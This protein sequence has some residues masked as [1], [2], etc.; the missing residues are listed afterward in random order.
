MDKKNRKYSHEFKME[1]IRLSEEEA[2]SIAEVASLLGIKP[3]KLTRWHARFGHQWEEGFSGN[4][5]F[6]LE[7]D[8]RRLR[9]ENSHL[10]VECAHMKKVL[11]FTTAV[12]KSEH[13]EA[14]V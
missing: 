4:V 13:G 12:L 1:A 8:L 5:I 7:E 2:R 6:G 10:R 11:A 9:Q 14:G 3:K